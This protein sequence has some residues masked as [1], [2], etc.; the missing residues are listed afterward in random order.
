MEQTQNS[1][2]LYKY[3]MYIAIM[4]IICQVIG[5]NFFHLSHLWSFSAWFLILLLWVQTLMDKNHKKVPPITVLSTIVSAL[6][7]LMYLLFIFTG[8]GISG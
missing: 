2:N 8:V 6:A 4:L 7:T 3:R 5:I 1:L